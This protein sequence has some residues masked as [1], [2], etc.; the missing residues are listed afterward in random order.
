MLRRAVNV[1]AQGR[2][3]NI[4]WYQI[5]FTMKQNIDEIKRMQ[6]LAGI[7]KENIEEIKESKYISSEEQEDEDFP[8]LNDDAI[9]AYLKSVI[10]PKYIKAVDS[11]MD[12]EEGYGESSMYF[13]DTPVDE[14][15]FTIP[16]SEVERWAKQEMS[17]Y[18]FS[19]P[20]EFPHK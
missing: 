12:D 19:K 15:P 13:F 6:Q 3:V 1:V 10:E 9:R 17:Y 4:Y 20:D 2:I 11:F 8:V 16:D 5:L 7:L 14:N 18:L